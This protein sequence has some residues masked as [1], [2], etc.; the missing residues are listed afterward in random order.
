MGGGTRATEA[1]ETLCT[2]RSSRHHQCA[3]LRVVALFHEHESPKVKHSPLVRA[4]LVGT[5][6]RSLIQVYRHEDPGKKLSYD[7][8]RSDIQRR[9][10]NA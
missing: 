6:E 7:V 8:K 1:K 4:K 5:G 3:F 2:D 10:F 9:A